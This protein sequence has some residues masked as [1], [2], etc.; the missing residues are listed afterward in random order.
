MFANIQQQKNNH[1][2]Q[3]KSLRIKLIL[4]GAVRQEVCELTKEV[5]HFDS[6]GMF[7]RFFIL[8]RAQFNW[9]AQKW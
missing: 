1:E 3:I 7:S 2:T 8:P 5:E 6:F 4:I 9:A